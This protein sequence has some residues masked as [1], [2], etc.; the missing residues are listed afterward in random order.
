MTGLRRSAFPL[1]ALFLSVAVHAAWIGNPAHPREGG[2]A[3]L[4][5]DM[6]ERDVVLSGTGGAVVRSLESRG[7]FFEHRSSLTP[8]FQ[9]SLRVLPF[10]GRAGLEGSAFN[11]HMAGGGVGLHFSPEEP[12]GPVHVGLQAAWEGRAGA[13]KRT[14]ASGDKKYDR[15]YWSEASL[16]AG[17]SWAP[18]EV[19]NLY[20][21]PVWT[22]LDVHFNVAGAR[23]DWSEDQAWGAFFGAEL[24]PGDAWTLGAEFRAGHEQSASFSLRYNY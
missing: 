20:G 10:T 18:V 19:L 7:L 9:M 15:L 14:D 11:P 1:V 22:K 24:V 3:G 8:A 17:V 6:G 16:A 13:R 12:L 5:Y 23:G 4:A 2:G 21:G